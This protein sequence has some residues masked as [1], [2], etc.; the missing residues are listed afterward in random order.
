MPFSRR[1]RSCLLPSPRE[2]I[3]VDDAF[4]T[5]DAVA[6][7]LPTGAASLTGRGC[8]LALESQKRPAPCR[9]RPWCHSRRDNQA[10]LTGM[11]CRAVVPIVSK[12]RAGQQLL[13]AGKRGSVWP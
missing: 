8:C 9:A 6:L 7:V 2:T 10:R 5:E 11:S 12:L 4:R 1:A 13:A 3:A